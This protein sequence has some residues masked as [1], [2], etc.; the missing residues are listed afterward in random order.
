MHLRNRVL[1]TNSAGNLF[2]IGTDKES[3]L[4]VCGENINGTKFSARKLLLTALPAIL[5]QAQTDVFVR[6]SVTDGFI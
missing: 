1:R 6:S 3:R 2:G 5:A 4:N